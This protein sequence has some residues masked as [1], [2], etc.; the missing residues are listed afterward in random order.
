M[1]NLQLLIK[2]WAKSNKKE[3]IIA[4]AFLM[5]GMIISPTPTKIIEKVSP[6]VV[7]KR[8]IEYV[9]ECKE[10]MALLKKE[11]NLRRQIMEVA[12]QR[13]T[14]SAEAMFYCSEAFVAT[15][16]LDFDIVNANALE[17]YLLVPPLLDLTTKQIDLSKQLEEIK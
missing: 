2:N 14:I 8:E 4:G 16:H 3:L 5:I 11:N 7:I 13:L 9:D 6:E 17:M 15:N 10:P 1:K 12:D